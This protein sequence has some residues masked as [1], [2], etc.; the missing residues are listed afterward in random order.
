[1]QISS[2]LVIVMI[3]S[4]APSTAVQPRMPADANVVANCAVGLGAPE[5][6]TVGALASGVGELELVESDMVNVE[7]AV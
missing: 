6:V 4:A 7:E 1:M 2:A 3:C 5:I